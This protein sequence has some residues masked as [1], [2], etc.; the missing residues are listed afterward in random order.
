M[1]IQDMAEVTLNF[2]VL[3]YSFSLG[4]MIDVELVDITKRFGDVMAV[5]MFR[6]ALKRVRSSCF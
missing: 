6:L 2:F 3:A 4:K 1:R 5:D